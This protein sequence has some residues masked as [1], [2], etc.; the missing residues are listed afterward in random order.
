[1][2]FVVEYA[3]I[4]S[5]TEYV[6]QIPCLSAY[7]LTTY[8]TIDTL[9]VHGNNGYKTAK[10][11]L[12]RSGNGYKKPFAVERTKLILFGSITPQEH[13]PQSNSSNTS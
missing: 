13:I 9:G 12:L 6:G 5:E 2:L 11:D 10:E 8:L 1:M 4:S 7:S 3:I